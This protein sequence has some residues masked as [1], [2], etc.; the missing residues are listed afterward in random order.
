MNQ[1]ERQKF[2]EFSNLS[3]SK[4]KYGYIFKK[5]NGGKIFLNP[6]NGQNLNKVEVSF[7]ATL[8]LNNLPPA[9]GNGNKIK[10]GN[11][12]EDDY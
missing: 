12:L 11:I 8:D 1:K 3:N 2:E 10:L 6:L 5:G 9:I 7:K 4:N